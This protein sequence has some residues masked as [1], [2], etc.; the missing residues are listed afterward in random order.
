MIVDPLGLVQEL[1]P[2][3]T[4]LIPDSY[5]ESDLDALDEVQR[6]LDD[7]DSN[8]FN[9]DMWRNR[10]PGF[11][12]GRRS[13]LTSAIKT[14]ETLQFMPQSLPEDK[15]LISPATIGGYAL[16]EKKW[17]FFTVENMEA[18]TWQD[19]AYDRLQLDP[20]QKRVIQTLVLQ[21]NKAKTDFDDLITG[22][23]RGLVVL[24]H[25]PP[26]CGKTMTAG[27]AMKSA[28]ISKQIH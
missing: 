26:G 28:H 11:G 2:F 1:P 14:I 10:H 4:E 5:D 17:G 13:T 19:N 3:R 7:F 16:G 23:G 20:G 22:K 12:Y 21:H 9:L 24:L 6:A 18:V 27:K 25:G 15:L 8:D